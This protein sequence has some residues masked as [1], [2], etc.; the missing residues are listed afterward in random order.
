MMNKEEFT[1]AGFKE[2]LQTRKT[3]HEKDLAWA[4]RIMIIILLLLLLLGKFVVIF[5]YTGCILNGTDDLL[6][7][8]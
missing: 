3:S 5:I 8:I 1:V 2:T 7:R 4:L 6:P